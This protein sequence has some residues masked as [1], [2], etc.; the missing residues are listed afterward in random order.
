[1]E[2]IWL[3]Q[4]RIKWKPTFLLRKHNKKKEP[5]FSFLSNYQEN[6]GLNGLTVASE[7]ALINILPSNTIT[8]NG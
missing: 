8:V 5:F 4:L 2:Y 6:E 3:V 7:T 1:M